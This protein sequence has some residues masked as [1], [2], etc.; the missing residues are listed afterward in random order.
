[1][2]T[3]RRAF[4]GTGKMWV[5]GTLLSEAAKI[6]ATVG[7]QINRVLTTGHTGET[8]EDP[9]KCE[10]SIDGSILRQSSFTARLKRFRRTQE[11]VTVKVQIGDQVITMRGKVGPQKF[12]TENGKSTF[13]GSFMGDEV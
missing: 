12:A 8:V 7:G 3:S 10:I 5:N 1:M 2:S 11:D 13:S 4:A 6:D 9:T